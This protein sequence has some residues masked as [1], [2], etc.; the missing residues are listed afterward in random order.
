MEKELNARI[1]IKIDSENAWNL[2]NTTFAPLSG[3]MCIYRMNDGSIRIK[4]GDGATTVGSLEFIDEQ[5]QVE[6]TNLS[7]TVY[8]AILYESDEAITDCNKWLTNGYAKTSTTTSN[9]P[10]QCTGND[11]WGVIFFIAENAEMGTGT[12]MY[13]PIDG[14]NKGRVFTRSLTRMASGQDSPVEGDWYRLVI[15]ED[16]S[17]L[18][19]TVDN[20]NSTVS[21]LSREVSTL[22]GTVGSYGSRITA[23]ESS[24]GDV[25]NS[26]NSL[27]GRVSINENSIGTIQGNVTDLT[28]EVGTISTTVDSMNSTLSGMSVTVSGLQLSLNSKANTNSPALTGTPTAPTASSG[29]NNTQIA[30]TAFVQ[31]AISG[32]GSGVDVQ[33]SSS[34]PS[35]QS[36]GDLWFKIL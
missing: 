36:T 21:G 4:V 30:T 29:T 1:Q 18:E 7:E 34:Q 16:I 6:V 33:L 20:L 8:K 19:A 26:V 22:E 15:D 25:K 35:G 5:L 12:Q 32:F 9:L 27:I 11:R 28:S 2:V 10:P 24:V 31:N 14:D 17:A 3:E 13:Y 23:V